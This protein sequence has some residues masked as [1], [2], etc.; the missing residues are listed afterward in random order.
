MPASI[1]PILH[2]ATIAEIQDNYGDSPTE[3]FPAAYKHLRIMALDPNGIAL[4]QLERNN[5]KGRDGVRFLARAV[6]YNLELLQKRHETVLRWQ[7]GRTGRKCGSGCKYTS[8]YPGL[9]LCF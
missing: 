5:Q 1:V 8:S 6:R 9:R 4:S 2:R 7:M 3:M